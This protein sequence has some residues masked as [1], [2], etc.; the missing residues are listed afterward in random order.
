MN[1]L[2]FKYKRLGTIMDSHIALLTLIK[3]SSY[4]VGFVV[5]SNFL[6]FAPQEGSILL[7]LMVIDVVTGVVRSCILHGGP[8]IRSSIG[9]RGVL[10]KILTLTGLITLAITFKGIGY[11][12]TAAIQGIVTVFI[13]AE[14][15]SILGNIHSSLTLK[16]KKEYDAVAFLVGIVRRMLEK[17]S[18][19]ADEIT[20]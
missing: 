9:T 6:G 12:A 4:A 15:Y 14:S 2:Y 19:R 5:A 17:Y 16:E 1:M 10:A 3:N 18:A 13:L 11:S 20:K 8:S 7:T